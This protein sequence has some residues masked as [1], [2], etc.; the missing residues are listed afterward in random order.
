MEPPPRVRAYD[1]TTDTSVYEDPAD[2]TSPL[3]LRKC[4]T[5]HALSLA[6]CTSLTLSSSA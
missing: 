4:V 6:L 5:V 2:G 1:P 3:S